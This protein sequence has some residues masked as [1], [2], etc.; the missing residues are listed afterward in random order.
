MG[1]I[2]YVT[3]TMKAANYIPANTSE[4]KW[5]CKYMREYPTMPTSN[6]LKRATRFAQAGGRVW[7]AIKATDI[8]KAVAWAV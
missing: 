8:K 6:R 5:T 4:T 1:A 3:V 7:N 2:K